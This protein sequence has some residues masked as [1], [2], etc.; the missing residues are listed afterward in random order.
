[1]GHSNPRELQLTSEARRPWRVAGEWIKTFEPEYL[2]LAAC[3]AGKSEVVRDVFASVDALRQIY[4]SPI[5]LYKIHTT[6]LGVLIFMLLA[7]GK[8]NPEQS[9]ALRLAHFAMSGGQL[10]RWRR[11]ETRPGEE[12]EGK[13]W[14][15]VGAALDFG[16]WD[17]FKKLFPNLRWDSR[18]RASV[19]GYT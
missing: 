3:E 6:P 18:L 11:H 10:Y 9:Q 19:F 12:L 17:L 16:P 15:A 5:S 2:F 8:I 4:A 13:L 7:H 14:D 1:M